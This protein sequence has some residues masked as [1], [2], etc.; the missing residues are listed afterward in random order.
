MREGLRLSR[1]TRAAYEAGSAVLALVA[2]DEELR[3]R[4]DVMSALKAPLDRLASAVCVLATAPRQRI[5][6]ARR[7]QGA[8]ARQ[9]TTSALLFGACSEIRRR[10]RLHF[11][12]ARW[13]IVRR[14]FGEGIGASG[15]KPTS[16]LLLA[17]TILEGAARHPEALRE[18]RVHRASLER[19]TALTKILETAAPERKV[20]HE[21]RRRV[22]EHLSE[23]AKDAVL[24]CE[25]IL[26]AAEAAG[27]GAA[28]IAPLRAAVLAAAE[29]ARRGRV[30][31]LAPRAQ[32][33]A[34]KGK[35][36]RKNVTQHNCVLDESTV[37]RLACSPGENE[38]RIAA[39]SRGA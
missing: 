36:R 33:G 38:E 13:Q 34:G 22:A 19:V 3:R 39:A 2:D 4:L 20:L 18:A 7:V 30:P 15:T 9:E 17:R 16:A 29:V 10:I 14:S 32:G 21:D 25:A 12:G 26:H 5:S 28:R 35:A 31:A 11:R 8:A 37:D 23:V 6:A 1:A 27:H 24:A